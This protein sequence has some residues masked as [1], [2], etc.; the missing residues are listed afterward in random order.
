[1]SRNLMISAL[2][3]LV[4]LPAAAVTTL[5][6]TDQEF[7]KIEVQDFRLLGAT[8]NWTP[9]NRSALII[10]NTPR[11]P[12]LVELARPSPDL[13]FVEGIGFTSFAGRISAR[14]DNVIVDGFRYPIKSIYAL[15]R[16]YAKD[17]VSASHKR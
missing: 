17:L 8:P 2:L 14:F 15:D 3:C 10:W 7:S 13:K 16:A 5:Q 12:Y 9:L 11:R 6:N 4:A 1:M